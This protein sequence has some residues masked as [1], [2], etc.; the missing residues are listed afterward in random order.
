MIDRCDP[1]PDEELSAPA[2]LARCELLD[3]YWENLNS[4][5]GG[6]AVSR[7]LDPRS[8]ELGLARDLEVLNLLHALRH[9]DEI[10]DRSQARTVRLLPA[11]SA[12]PQPSDG[13]LGR[14]ESGGERAVAGSKDPG[15]ETPG[16]AEPGA[17]Q[18]ALPRQ[19]GKYV[20]ID[21]LDG[22]GQGQ[23]FRV[24]HRKLG[25][26]F[27]LKLARRPIVFEPPGVAEPV[28]HSTLHREGKLLAQ[29]DHPNL[30]RVVDLDVHEGRL[31]VVM[32]RVHGLTLDQFADQHRP[33]PRRAAA[34]VGE[35]ARAVAYLHAR[36]VVHQDIKPRNVLIDEDGR[37]RLIDFGLAR[38]RHVWSSDADNPIGGT[39]EYMSPEQA[40]GRT[41]R[42][43]PCTDIFGLGG[44]LYHLLTHRPLYQGATWISSRW[45]A[46]NADYV[47]ISQVNPAA[48]RSL[49][50]ICRKALSAEP[51]DRFHTAGELEQA[52]SRYLSRRGL[53]W[54]ALGGAVACAAV[55]LALELRYRFDRNAGA[56]LT[57]PPPPPAIAAPV[58]LMIETLRVDHFTTRDG[59]WKSLPIGLSTTVHE[60]EEAT[61]YAELSSPAYGYLL[62]LNPDGK[63]QLCEPRTAVEEPLQGSII[64]FPDSTPY[65]P[66][67]DGSGLQ[68]F[69][70][71]CAR[72]PLPAYEK[73]AGKAWLEE[74]W[75]QV[76][77][78]E[79]RG[80]WRHDGQAATLVSSTARGPLRQGPGPPALFDKVCRHLA[81]L[82]DI[83]AIQA[84]AFPVIPKE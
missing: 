45:Q 12:L 62:A 61:V 46:M 50:L 4:P 69:L 70:V 54:P 36:G 41:D 51:N 49:E 56:N 66:F 26:E 11:R 31:F 40:L 20:V 19:I 72:R 25:K 82:P 10:G 60:G 68:V 58:R 24:L 42:L 55:L 6:E 44:L 27:V 34:L 17:V 53:A 38:Q 16:T 22:G 77:V 8:P 74:N 57:T 81:T 29:L 13:E 35:L 75:K 48:P 47:P 71:L 7:P 32:E 33:G 67:T 39:A 76:G 37:P 5:S 28:T 79:S 80:V 64:R 84:I 30:V 43:G 63:V 1:G 14:V 59:V 2:E 23:V 83:D 9:S 52:L 21:L 78:E 65:F 15:G 3:E 73:W 18:V